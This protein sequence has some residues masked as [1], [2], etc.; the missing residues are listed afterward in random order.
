MESSAVCFGFANRASSRA[1]L[2]RLVE[3]GTALLGPGHINGRDGIRACI[4]NYRTTESDLD[5][6]VDRVVEL[7]SP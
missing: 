6:V 5:L 7:C 1:V 2:A 4:A 3:G